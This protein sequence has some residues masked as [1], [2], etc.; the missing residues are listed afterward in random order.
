MPEPQPH[1]HPLRILILG[2]S[3]AGPALASYLLLS[4]T[5]SSSLS[6]T[7]L[8][9]SP[10]PRTTGQNI[11]LRGVGIECVQRLGLL[12][13]IRQHLTGEAGVHW[14]DERD[15][16]VASIPAS[17]AG[18]AQGPTAELEILR[19]RLAGCLVRRCE[20]LGKE[21]GGSGV[22]FMYG[23]HVE[24]IEQ[25]GE[26]VRVKLANSKREMVF[27]LVVGAD[28]LQ[29]KTRRQVFGLSGET[30]RVH[31][32]HIYGAFFSMPR[33]EADDDWRRWFHAPGRRGVMIRPSDRPD[34][35]TVFMHKK[36][37]SEEEAA[38]FEEAARSAYGETKAQKRLMKETFK[39][40]VWREERILR[41]LEESEDFYYS[42]VAQVKMEKWIHG[43]VVLLGDAA[44]SP[45]P[46]SGMGTTLALSGAYNLA[47]ALSTHP[48][49]IPAALALYEE[50]QRPLV[51][52]GQRLS[53]AISLLYDSDSAWRV[54]AVNWFAAGVS[55]FGPVMKAVFNVVGGEANRKGM[56]LREFGLRR[57]EEVDLR[58]ELE[59][60]I[61]EENGH[62][63][64]ERKRRNSEL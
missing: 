54:W 37:S 24:K 40:M 13:T 43:R 17:K 10:T 42:P 50:T 18:E 28:G 62:R 31:R 63:R 23:D 3:I 11:D 56:G 44:H 39:G 25:E 8:E 46:L 60:L 48:D 57:G 2:T 35:V 52:A 5:L 64:R 51:E 9:R 4:P 7:L 61:G 22:E 55:Y 6:I 26:E 32:L 47:G 34:R 30:S 58:F 53:P 14:V 29:S 38:P 45:S 33:T 21:R 19:G 1:P 15:F 12:P 16:P 20:E 59:V 27:D 49:D 41:E 36:T